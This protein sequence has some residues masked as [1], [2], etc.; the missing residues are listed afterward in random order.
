MNELH[1]LELHELSLLIRSGK[2]SPVE[3][4]EAQLARI[5]ALD[6]RL[7]SYAQVTAERA[8]EQAR[9]AE[10]ELARG[11]CR[12][13]LH[14]IPLAF[15]DLL[16][17][18]GVVTAAGMPLRR[19]FIPREDATV[20]ARLREAGS[21]MLGKLQ[22]TEGAFA[23]HHPDI[24]APNNPW[25]AGHWAGASSSGC[26]V[27]TAAGL[28]YA[29]LGSDTGGSIRFPCAANGL[30][31]LKPTWGRVSRHGSFELAASLDHIGPITRSARDALFLLSS[32]A[33][34]DPADPTSL[35]SVCLQVDSLE[36]SFQGLRVGVDEQWISDGVDPLIQ[37]ALSQVLGIIQAGGGKLHRV[38]MPDTRAV[39][40]NWESH[41]GVQTALAHASTYPRRAAEYGPAL[42]RLIDGGR[43][44]SG[45]DYQR[46]LLDGQR[47]H[48]ELEALLK[49]IDLLLAPV[50]PYAAPSHE[51]LANLA[52]DPE[53]NRRLIQFTAPFNV[54]GHPCLSLP[55]GFTA[56]GLPI[57]CQFIAGKGAEALLCRAGMALQSVTDWHKVRPTGF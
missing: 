6:G 12:S 34:H 42:S 49:D 18:A 43:A 16:H 53:A 40:A 10:R 2:L 57:G 38:R 8:L 32:I 56:E 51:Q 50:Q 11:H 9:E 47:F 39:S 21:V 27:A 13:P 52:Q 31:G 23:I 28:C 35:P 20:V 19:D 22:M 30:T 3:V 29:S 4:T 25:H 15:K 36:G 7:H 1:Y 33:G 41:C 45:M 5:E 44:L 48:G 37:Q 46:I 55:C 24:V 17:T 54:S 14:G 26:G